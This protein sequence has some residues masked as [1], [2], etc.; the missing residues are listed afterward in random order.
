MWQTVMR[1]DG[2]YVHD[3]AM[4]AGRLNVLMRKRD[5]SSRFEDAA[6]GPWTNLVKADGVAGEAF[7]YIPLTPVAKLENNADLLPMIHDA[8]GTFDP[9]RLWDFANT[10][11]EG[12]ISWRQMYAL[13]LYLDFLEYPEVFEILE[14]ESPASFSKLRNRLEDEWNN[15]IK[16]QCVPE[17]SNY[18]TPLYSL[19][20]EPFHGAVN[21][22]RLAELFGRYEVVSKRLLPDMCWQDLAPM[23]STL[24]QT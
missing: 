11:S 8:I 10:N 15:F 12:R 21:L 1:K 24:E 17:L 7:P 16:T 13:Q 6:V 9:T 19:N 23:L 22:G 2:Y 20:R 4:R 3:I 14:A 5:V 18:A